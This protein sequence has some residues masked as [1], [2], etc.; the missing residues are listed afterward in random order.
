MTVTLYALYS[1]VECC[2]Q[3]AAERQKVECF[4]PSPDRFARWV[5]ALVNGV[6]QS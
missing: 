6:A 4:A 1:G 3:P 5:V 2:R